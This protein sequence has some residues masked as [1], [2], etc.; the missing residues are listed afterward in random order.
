MPPSAYATRLLTQ[1]KLWSRCFVLHHAW[2]SSRLP[3]RLD[4]GR[5]AIF[6]LSLLLNHDVVSTHLELGWDVA[7]WRLANLIVSEF[8]HH[9][10][11]L[12]GLLYHLELL[13]LLIFG[14]I[15][16]I[17]RVYL[18]ITEETVLL[19]QGVVPE[20]SSL[21]PGIAARPTFLVMFSGNR[22]SNVKRIGTDVIQLLSLLKKVVV[23]LHLLDELVEVDPQLHLILR[24]V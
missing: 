2:R 3:R 17:Q 24:D 7:S 8:I 15:I 12:N 5:R 19:L 14:F 23:E 6:S 10:L 4:L 18:F 13:E 20:S 9:S 22:M 21:V 16:Y 1:G 11:I